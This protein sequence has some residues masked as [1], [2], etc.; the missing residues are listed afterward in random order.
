MVS[1]AGDTRPSG[2]HPMTHSLQHP[3]CTADTEGLTGSP[4]FLEFSNEKELNLGSAFDRPGCL[5][6]HSRHVKPS[7]LLPPTEVKSQLVAEMTFQQLRGCLSLGI[8]LLTDIKTLLDRR[9]SWGWN[10]WH[11]PSPES[12]KLFCLRECLLSPRCKHSSTCS[13]GHS[14]GFKPNK[15]ELVKR[16]SARVHQD[17]F[18]ISFFTHKLHFCW[19]GNERHLVVSEYLVNQLFSYFIRYWKCDA[20]E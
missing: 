3:P 14:F 11:Q 15:S 17:S 1:A 5:S 13:L 18:Q 16:R 4:K 2:I 9:M 10:F 19:Q 7:L 6:R 12:L 8:L 20:R